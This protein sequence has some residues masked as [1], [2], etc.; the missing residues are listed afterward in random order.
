M[1]P[2][3]QPAIFDIRQYRIV[4]FGERRRKIPCDHHPHIVIFVPDRG[5]HVRIRRIKRF[6]QI[7]THE[8]TDRETDRIGSRGREPAP[9]FVQQLLLVLTENRRRELVAGCPVVN[10][11]QELLDLAHARVIIADAGNHKSVQLIFIKI[12][13]RQILQKFRKILP[14]CEVLCVSSQLR[15]PDADHGI[16]RERREEPGLK[17]LIPLILQ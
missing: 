1:C 8:H 17:L 2:V 4:L 5:D 16:R 11:R 12:R 13:M 9:D 14:V 6:I 15:R 3:V 10:K 7:I